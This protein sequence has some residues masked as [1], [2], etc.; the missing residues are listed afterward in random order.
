MAQPDIQS[1]SMPNMK[2]VERDDVVR[3]RLE[4]R[5]I[6]QGVGFRPFVYRLA[7]DLA[8][9]GWIRNDA[10][11]V[12]IEVEGDA[13]HIESLARGLRE[14]APSLARVDSVSLRECAPANA[15]TQSKELA[16]AI[17]AL[18]IV[19]HATRP[20]DEAISSAG[21][22]AWSA[23][24]KDYQLIAMPSVFCAG[25]MLDWE[26]PTGGYLLTACW[27]TGRSAGLGA[28]AYLSSLAAS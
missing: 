8:L 20:L 2:T 6:V 5:G 15:I 18:P 25:E 24:D 10:A 23:L 27:A 4:V 21:G 19:L 7:R 26:A 9:D 12:T 22:V 16:A 1:V 3:R 13:A 28:A 14:Q 17:K 11:G